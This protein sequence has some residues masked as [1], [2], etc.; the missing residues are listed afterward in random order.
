L[1]ARA[2]AD[3][4]ALSAHE[5]AFGIVDLIGNVWQYTSDER[6]DGHTRFVLLRGGARYQPLAASDFQNWYF[7]S[8]DA[9]NRLGGGAAVRL[10]R[11]AK[12]FLMGPSYERAATVGFRCAYDW[13][14]APPSPP[15]PEQEASSGGSF[16]GSFFFF[17]FW[18][19]AVGTGLT[20]LLIYLHALAERHLA[21]LVQNPAGFKQPPARGGAN[22]IGAVTPAEL[23]PM[24]GQGVLGSGVSASAT[25]SPLRG[26]DFGVPVESSTGEEG[27][28]S[29]SMSAPGAGY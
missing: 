14:E 3:S 6:S 9:A 28:F 2:P 22:A 19:G 27:W 15:P 26:A 18:V 29:G 12:Y 10:D 8:S 13:G 24:F 11:H 1:D 4:E 5:N 7:A 23:A 21:D 16:I 20:F 25:P 17:I